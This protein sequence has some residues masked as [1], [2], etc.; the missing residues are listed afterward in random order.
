MTRYDSR[1]PA[2]LGASD[3]PDAVDDFAGDV[4]LLVDDSVEGE[5]MAAALRSRG[6]AV[7]EAP[8]AMLESRVAS[9]SP[10][11]V[12]VDVDQ[13]GAIDRVRSARAANKAS[14][15]L[16]CVGDPL[17]AAELPDVSLLESVFERPVDVMRLVERVAAVAS[18]AGPGYA[19]R[20]T[21]P[22]PMYAP[23]P[24]VPPAADSVPPVSEL[25][26]ADDPLELGGFIDP[27]DDAGVA[28][29]LMLEPIPLSPE[30]S[31]LITEAEERVRSSLERHS[32]APVPAGDDSVLPAE[33]LALLDEPL[34]A[35]E[36]NIG[37]GLEGTGGRS[38]SSSGGGTG[39]GSIRL[40]PAAMTPI[41]RQTSS[42]SALEIAEAG[43][44]TPSAQASTSR[45]AP[46]EPGRSMLAG[47]PAPSR[48][49]SVAESVRDV[50]PG[51]PAAPV[52]MPTLGPADV[53]GPDLGQPSEGLLSVP[54]LSPPVRFREPRDIAEG[55]TFDRHSVSPMAEEAAPL[56]IV[57][58][59]PLPPS[60][61]A[62][63]LGPPTPSAL[64]P[65][66]VSPTTRGKSPAAQ[67]VPGRRESSSVPV[68]FG[69]GE[70][71]RPLARAIA[72]R[73][74]CVVSLAANDGVRK[75]V[76][77]EG[78]I[79]TAASE[80]ADETL[81]GFLV[82]RGDLDRGLGARL[83][84]KLP[85]S[86]RHAGAALIAQGHLAQDDLWPVLRAH[87]EWLVG[88]A[89]TS[90]P[91][92]IELEDE[93][94]GRLKLEPGVFGGSTGAEVFVETARRV[95]VP[96]QSLAVLG[97]LNARFDTGARAALL[98]E[99][100]LSDDERGAVEGAAGKTVVEI[101]PDPGAELLS[102]LRA[103][104][105]LEVLSLHAPVRRPAATSR[106]APDPIDEDAVRARVRARAALVREGDYFSL[107]G[108]GRA[109]TS[110]EIKRAYLDL[111]RS[112][113]PARLLTAR[114]ADL[115]DDVVLI[116]EVLEE[117]YE[118][119]REEPR[120]ERYRRAIEAGP[121]PD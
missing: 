16:L 85:P 49:S 80:I 55:R 13:P 95:L 32:S 67:S 87:A 98:A 5:D 24:S 111:R 96:S 53:F 65:S 7:I 93:P 33:T 68:V 66:T 54:P 3:V 14:F 23:R 42:S 61:T 100:A 41:P 101:C 39:S 78:D 82:S 18:P 107:L 43:L 70:G 64:A 8:L 28:A 45:R 77:Q 21:T 86:G 37:T 90:G 76:L 27:G 99:C 36:E 15:E 29:G 114:T 71:L 75:I 102:V 112:L 108:V 46:F 103:L 72:G 50:L 74:T 4:V 121:P 113:E 19:S 40:S 115:R 92:T 12:V 73:F 91:G 104:V 51:L 84:G 17:R 118:I 94:S 79:V 11:V 34:D 97:G 20:G 6:F 88:R 81:V 10:R 83:A 109:A 106:D 105:E 9:E 2:D 1:S 44:M 58:S 120:R 35:F 117:A 31:R 38:G 26:P 56:L 59:M 22:P 119:L 47:T 30:L 110:Y 116:L 57:P 89:M 60:A 62:R 25:S 63:D 69:D 48:I 52:V